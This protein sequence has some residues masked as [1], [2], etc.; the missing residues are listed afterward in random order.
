MSRAGALLVLNAGSSSLNFVLFETMPQLTATARGE[1]EN[2]DATPHLLVHDA[3]GTIL[4]EQHWPEGCK[5]SFATV[6][7]ALLVFADAHL[8]PRGL[9]AVGHRIVNGGMEHAAPERITPQLLRALTDLI[10]LDPLHMQDN[11]APIHA[12]AAARLGVPQIACF[13]MAFHST[14][15]LKAKSFALP[16]PAKV[17]PPPSASVCFMGL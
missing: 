9:A 14:M 5:P 15:P 1:V 7:D 8:G 10:P 11:L 6:L 3:A 2:L 13:D 4:A 17:S 12:V 16:R